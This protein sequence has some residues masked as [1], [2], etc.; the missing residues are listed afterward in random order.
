MRDKTSI[1]NSYRGDILK[2][3]KIMYKYITIKG[4]INSYNYDTCISELLTSFIFVNFSFAFH[5]MFHLLS[6][7]SVDVKL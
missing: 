1:T 5:S 7:I 2:A 3:I 4:S 6:R